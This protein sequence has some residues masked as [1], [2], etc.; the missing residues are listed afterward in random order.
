MEPGSEVLHQCFQDVPILGAML[1][2]WRIMASSF[3]VVYRK[4]LVRE[5]QDLFVAAR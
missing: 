1:E 3:A 4:T 2:M 5:R